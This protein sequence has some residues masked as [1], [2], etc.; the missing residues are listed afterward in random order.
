LKKSQKV[1][2]VDKP[3]NF[4]EKADAALRLPLSVAATRKVES[5]L[6][7]VSRLDFKF[8]LTQLDLA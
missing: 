8:D 3:T 6:G 4:L 5:W 2:K 1:Q 7:L